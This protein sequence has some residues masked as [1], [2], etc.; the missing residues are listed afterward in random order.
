LGIAQE[1]SGKLV[2][3]VRQNAKL[4]AENNNLSYVIT[5]GPPG[6]GCPVISSLAGADLALLVT[7]PTLSGIHDL[8]RVIRLCRHFNV[9]ASVCINKH[10]V[11]EENTE[12]IES[13]CAKEGIEVV[14]KIPFDNAVTEAILLGIPVVEYCDNEVSRRIR[15]LWKAIS[16]KLQQ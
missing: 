11:N 3:A 10:D 7:E 6:T 8:E 1:N 16:A 12:R 15:E 5:D 4:I 14:A 9:P 2:A 13:Y